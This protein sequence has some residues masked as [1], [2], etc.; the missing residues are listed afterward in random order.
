MYEN[1]NTLPSHYTDA[2]EANMQH[3]PQQQGSRLVNLVDSNLNFTKPGDMFNADM[4]GTSEPEEIVERFGKSPDGV[5][6]K[7]RR[8]GFFTP[9]DDGNWLDD[10]D[11]AKSLSDP[12]NATMQAMMWGLERYRDDKIIEALDAP[13]R[14]GRT[15]ETTVAFPSSQIIA[16]DSW[17]YKRKG[18]TSTGDAPMTFAKLNRMGVMLDKSEIPGERVVVISSEQLGQLLTDPVITDRE[19]GVVNSLINR[20]ITRFMNASWVVSERLPLNAGVRTCFGF[21]KPAIMYRGRKLTEAQIVRRP[22]RKFNWYAYYKGTHGALRR[23][24]KAVVKILCAE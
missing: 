24:D 20:E 9:Y 15:G 2:F 12:A 14:E 8:V 13:S 6:A 11:T 16:I 17:T 10:I 7:S 22:D 3:V 19:A 1:E 21:I 18:D 23:F 4:I 5:I